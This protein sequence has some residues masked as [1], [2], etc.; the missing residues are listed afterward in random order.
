MF[1]IWA[2]PMFRLGNEYLSEHVLITSLLSGSG[3]AFMKTTN[4]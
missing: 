4:V 2:G 3:V 1:C